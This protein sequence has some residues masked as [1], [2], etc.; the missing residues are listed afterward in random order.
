MIETTPFVSSPSSLM[1]TPLALSPSSLATSVSPL[2][3]LPTAHLL[4]GPSA[5]PANK[6]ARA[7]FAVTKSTSA[8]DS[9]LAASQRTN[10]DGAPV[11]I[12]FYGV[13]VL[14]G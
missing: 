11:M 6:A 10:C 7:L 8:R 3:R 13:P 2:I 9:A 5:A 12:S 1:M 14:L 4:G